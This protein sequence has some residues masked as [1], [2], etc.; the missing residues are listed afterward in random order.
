MR[1]KEKKFGGKKVTTDE[2]KIQNTKYKYRNSKKN[3]IHR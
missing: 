1:M 2:Y 3:N